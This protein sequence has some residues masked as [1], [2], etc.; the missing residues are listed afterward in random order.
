MT[1]KEKYSGNDQREQG[2]MYL[3]VNGFARPPD[4][5]QAVGNDESR[6]ST[7]RLPTMQGFIAQ[8]RRIAIRH[9]SHPI[10][11]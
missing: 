6:G 3:T 5:M 4:P 7:L 8:R 9:E 1:S 11:L 10:E 2:W